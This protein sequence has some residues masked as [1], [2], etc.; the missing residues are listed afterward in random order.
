MPLVK[1]FWLTVNGTSVYKV[2]LI[3]LFVN[4]YI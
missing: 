1:K 3:V 4:I 2:V